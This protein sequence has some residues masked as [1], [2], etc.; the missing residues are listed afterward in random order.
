MVRPATAGAILFN[1]A[2]RILGLPFWEA[3]SVREYVCK[4]AFSGTKLQSSK[5]GRAPC[6]HVIHILLQQLLSKS[7]SI[8][9]AILQ[10][11]FGLRRTNMT[12]SPRRNI[13]LMYLSLFTG[14]AFF[15][16][17]P[18]FGVS[19][20]ISFTFSSTMLQCR[21]KALTR[22]NSLWLLRQLMSTC[23]NIGSRI[24]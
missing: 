22:A 2:T 24:R 19:V 15:V 18:V 10:F 9:I 23:A 7:H 1:E 20:H 3:A 13:L 12:E 11:Q 6:H 16:P 14:L 8:I 17:F 4:A 21:S 5:G